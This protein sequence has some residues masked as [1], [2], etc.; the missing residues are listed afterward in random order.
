MPAR[1]PLVLSTRGNRPPFYSR[2][3][4][5]QRA[6]VL[7]QGHTARMWQVGLHPAHSLYRSLPGER[8]GTAKPRQTEAAAPALGRAY[9]VK[10]WGQVGCPSAPKCLHPPPQTD[11]PPLPS[12]SLARDEASAKAKE[13]PVPHLPPLLSA[14]AAGDR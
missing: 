12:Q 4:E 6:M 2:E 13:A 5:A 14:T 11:Y 7:V 8:L 9:G 3:T 1:P 10:S